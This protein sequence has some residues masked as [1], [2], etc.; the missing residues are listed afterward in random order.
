MSSEGNENKAI[1]G[2]MPTPMKYKNMAKILNC[3]P[4]PFFKNVDI[5]RRLRPKIII[6]TPI[7]SKVLDPNLSTAGLD[8]KQTADN[9]TDKPKM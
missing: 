5:V 3:L 6:T 9:I 1:T 2:P 8:K 4:L 7:K